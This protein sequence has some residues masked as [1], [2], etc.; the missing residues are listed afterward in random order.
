MSNFNFRQIYLVLFI[1]SIFLCNIANLKKNNMEPKNDQIIANG[2]TY[3]GNEH[4]HQCNCGGNCDCTDDES[5]E[6]SCGG[7][8]DCK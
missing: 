8:C 4:E 6:C 1:N 3:S 5:H 7:E 2:Y